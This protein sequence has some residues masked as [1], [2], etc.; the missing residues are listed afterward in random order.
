MGYTVIDSA[1][2]APRAVIFLGPLPLSGFNPPLYNT[3]I[4]SPGPNTVDSYPNLGPASVYGSVYG[5]VSDSPRTQGLSY[6][7]EVSNQY[8][9]GGAKLSPTNPVQAFGDVEPYGQGAGS[10]AATTQPY[11]I[12]ASG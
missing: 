10:V 1:S 12:A 7:N 6:S 8:K 3:P 2:P 9:N 5:G 4:A 11:A